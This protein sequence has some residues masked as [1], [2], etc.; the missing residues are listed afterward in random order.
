MLYSI[1]VPKSNYTDYYEQ[2]RFKLTWNI[3][4][5]LV[6]TLLLLSIVFA[7][8]E[9]KFVMHYGIGTGLTFFS[10]IYMAIKR[11]YRRVSIFLCIASYLLVS[12]SVWLVPNSVHYIEPF[13]IFI[14]SLYAYFALGRWW[15][16]AFL[17]GNVITTSTYFL[18]WLNPNLVE[19][20]ALTAVQT[21]TM[22]ME[23]TLCATIMGYIIHQ[24]ISTNMRA[25]IQ[26][27]K[28]NEEVVREKK[29]VERQDKEKTILLQE[30][31]HRVKNNLQ[32]ITSLLRMQSS[33]IVSKEAQLHFQ[34]AINR[35]MTMSLIHQKM[36]EK[37]NLGQVNLE[38][39]INS[40]VEDLIESG[41]SD[42]KI[43]FEVRTELER[44]GAKSIVPLALMLTELTS[45]TLK[46]A[47]KDKAAQPKIGIQILL[48][49]SDENAFVLEYSDNGQWRESEEESFGLELIETLT[50]QL[51]GSYSR[52]NDGQGTKYTFKLKKLDSLI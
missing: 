19:F 27:K 21:I 25:E 18:F 13:W 36:Y 34:D 7:F 6:V 33:K 22:G 39:Y 51:E 16:F 20:E 29:I 4:I 47:F 14:I 5:V 28:A 11:E 1:K 37:D 40:L 9:P 31:H 43:T 41:I 42:M 23:F 49:W 3:N 2:A 26:V 44:V 32:V 10:A 50:E 15:G 24:F 17:V 38:D 45:N 30:I 35:I 12:S 52:V 8:I 46:H 48:D